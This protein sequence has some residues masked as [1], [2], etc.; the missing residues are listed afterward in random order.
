MPTGGR[1]RVLLRL[2]AALLGAALLLGSIPARAVG[3]RETI[4]LPP[5]AVRIAPGTRI[6]AV[7]DVH[8]PGTTYVLGT[9][10]HRQQVRPKDGDRFIGAP[11]ARLTGARLLTGARHLG[12]AWIF[13]NQAPHPDAVRHGICRAEFPRCDRPQALFLD[14]RPLRPVA[15]L[16]DLVP[17]TWFFDYA[18][19]RIYLVEDPAGRRVELTHI[20]FAFGGKARN[21]WIENL[22]IEKYAAANQRGAIN[23]SGGG[24]G[25]TIRNNEVRWNYGYGITL[26]TGHRAIANKVHG[27]GQ[28]GIGGGTSTGILVEGNEIAFNAWNGTDCAW[29]C[30]GAKWGAVSN[31]VVRGNY[32]HHNGGVGLWT[33]D[34]CRNILIEGNRVEYNAGAGISHEISFEAVIRGNTLR[35]NGAA[36]YVWGWNAQIQ[37]QNSAETL[38]E[39]NR[40][41]LDLVRGGNGISLIQQDRGAQHAVRNVVVA[42][43]EIVKR[44]GGGALAGWFADFEADRF[45]ERNNRFEANRYVVAP[46]ARDEPA[47]FANA[48]VTFRAWQEGGADREGSAENDQP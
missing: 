19:G 34:G 15:R 16:D 25:W 42:G 22:T 5:D 11:G 12:Q 48:S 2:H 30:G 33:D 43:N 27:N 13:D 47:W 23:D 20:P 26:A 36:S 21:V 45:P 7:V 37:V 39:G 14:D 44:R 1:R 9:G 46:T 29:E 32:V 24:V 28:L 6:Q 4:A 17:G 10:I 41:E 35:G 8:P 40:L 18:A 38:V 31:M 3:P